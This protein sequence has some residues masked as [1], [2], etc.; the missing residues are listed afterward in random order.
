MFW[1]WYNVSLLLD[2]YSVF[3]EFLLQENTYHFSAN[4]IAVSI[5]PITLQYC[6]GRILAQFIL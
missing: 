1:L 4:Y 5:I 2:H 6:I 3:G